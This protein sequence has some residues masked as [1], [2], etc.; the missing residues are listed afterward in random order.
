MGI[1]VGARWSVVLF[2]DTSFVV[3]IC[4]CICICIC[5]CIRIRIRIRIRSYSR[6]SIGASFCPS[7]ATRWSQ[8]TNNVHNQ[9]HCNQVHHCT[10]KV[11]VHCYHHDLRYD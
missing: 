3:G 6:I 5:S 2:F 7:P 8:S 4:I 11:P 1:G 10:E 9:K